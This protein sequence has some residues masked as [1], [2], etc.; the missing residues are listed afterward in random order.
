[1]VDDVKLPVYL[2]GNDVKYEIEAVLKLFYG[3]ARFDFINL[4]KFPY[5]EIK[6]KCI[7]ITKVIAFCKAEIHFGSNEWD[8]EI[9][10]HCEEDFTFEV[11]YALYVLL[12]RVTGIR[13]PWGILTGIRPVHWIAN[14]I[15]RK[16]EERTRT[17]LSKY[18]DVSQSKI[19]LAIRIVNNQKPILSKINNGTVSLYIS[20]P[21][22][23]TRCS[24][25]SFVSH[26]IE[27][28][29]KLIPDYIKNL[30]REIELTGQI[31]RKNNT[32]ID[33]I[34]F[35]GGTPTS[36]SADEIETLLK[37]VA[38]NFD[39]ARIR[40]YSF[41]AG[42]ADTITEDKL[43]IIKKY[44]IT[45]ISVN[46]QTLNDEVL[47]T[48]GRCHTAE[49]TLTAFRLARKAG[50]DNIN[51]DVIAGLP[52][53]TAESFKDTLDK[54]IELDP[55]SIT[56]HTLTL[57][58]GAKIFGDA[59]H[60][61][62]EPVEADAVTE[63]VDYSISKL[64]ENGYEP[65]YLYRQKNTLSNLEN[66]GYAKRGKDCLYNIFIM[67]DTQTVIGMGSGASTKLV[68]PDG[69]IERILN[70]KYPYEYIRRFDELI[71]KR[72]GIGECLKKIS[73]ATQQ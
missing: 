29:A 71:E 53:D 1:M 63:M 59:I 24:Y 32:P 22:C 19:D 34:Y 12:K 51:M 60:P 30:C 49:D 72:G 35:G 7:V 31:I 45:R 10:P 9:G 54:V 48:I 37:C 14:I 68:Y 57:K 41:E 8:Y 46:P 20:V 28:A 66:I 23:P 50:F 6:E 16:G 61:E 38:E 25:C 52:T 67:D 27:F 18:Y 39:T 42:R 55:E 58:R 64:I 17:D 44:G 62:L 5:G 11:S 21:F 40:E 4:E 2:I 70:Y 73:S 3:T 26:S 65:Y 47:K 15:E 56:V 13:P 43:R 33:T 36:I 69:R